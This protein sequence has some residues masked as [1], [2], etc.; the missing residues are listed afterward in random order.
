MANGYGIWF[1]TSI[2]VNKTKVWDVLFCHNL[3]KLLNVLL[4]FYITRW[5]IKNKIK[6]NNRNAKCTACF[7][8]CIL[9]GF[10]LTLTLTTYI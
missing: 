10:T 9:W 4:S 6:F 7:L 2:S 5:H 8:S 1:Y 3:Y